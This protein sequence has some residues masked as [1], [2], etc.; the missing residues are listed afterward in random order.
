MTVPEGATAELAIQ[1]VNNVVVTAAVSPVTATYKIL[2]GGTAT[3][4]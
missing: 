1:I 2:P 3:G 4:A